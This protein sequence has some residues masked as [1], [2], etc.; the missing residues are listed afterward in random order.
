MIWCGIPNGVDDIDDG[1]DAEEV[2]KGRLHQ[3]PQL[4][5][6]ILLMPVACILVRLQDGADTTPITYASMFWEVRGREARAM[7]SC[8]S[9]WVDGSEGDMSPA[10]CRSRQAGTCYQQI[11]S[12]PQVKNMTEPATAAQAIQGAGYKLSVTAQ[13]PG[14]STGEAINATTRVTTLIIIIIIHHHHHLDHHCRTC[15]WA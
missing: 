13:L 1:G 4:A 5:Q 14:S 2:E 3:A 11:A 10:A 9:L 12:R 7:Q 6:V 8:R 15:V